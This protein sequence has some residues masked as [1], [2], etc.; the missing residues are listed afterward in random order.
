MH[1]TN[2]RLVMNDLLL[3]GRPSSRSR[4]LPLLGAS[5]TSAVASVMMVKMIAPAMVS[6]HAAKPATSAETMLAHR[7]TTSAKTVVKLADVAR[8]TKNMSS[9]F[10]ILQSR[11]V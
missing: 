8:T 4:L 3:V 10:M 9:S 6:I 11:L 2:V 1:T 7:H 5:V